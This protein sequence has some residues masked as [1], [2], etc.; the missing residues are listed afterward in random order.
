MR[1]G[2]GLAWPRGTALDLDWWSASGWM[3]RSKDGKITW[4]RARAA[5]VLHPFHGDHS[6]TTS[7]NSRPMGWSLV[8][9]EPVWGQGVVIDVFRRRRRYPSYYA[10]MYAQRI[11]NFFQ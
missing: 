8:L 4:L 6:G 1:G 5:E 2:S 10:S 7:L 11:A 3:G 9:R